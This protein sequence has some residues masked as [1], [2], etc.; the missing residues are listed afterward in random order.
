MK[1]VSYILLLGGTGAMGTNLVKVLEQQDGF[2]VVVTSRQKKQDTETTEYRQGNAHDTEWLLHILQEREWDA[3][4]DFMI[5]TT[6]EFHSRVELLLG[7]TKQYVYISS[8]RVYADSGDKLITEDSPRLLDVCNDKEYLK[9]D[10]YAL[11]KARQEDLLIHNNRKNW[12]IVRPYITFSHNR[13]QLGVMEKENWLIPALNNRPIVFS[14][15][16]A[17]HYTTMTDGYA[18]AQ[19]IAAVITRPN[20][21]GEIFHITSSQSQKWSDVLKWYMEAIFDIKGEY[22][23]VYY[24][25]EWNPTFGG[26][27]YQWKYDRLYDRS[28]DNSKICKFVSDYTSVSTELALKSAIKK[29]IENYSPNILDLNQ[30]VEI[31]RGVLTGDYLSLSQTRGKK[32]K[33][34]LIAYKLHVFKPLQNIYH[35]WKH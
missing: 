6:D 18:V 31:E 9:T 2:R 21:K 3:I 14:K 20:A 17:E 16:I 7:A 24:T 15:D 35:L 4:V 22:P 26:A 28:F 13:L 23:M 1:K 29:F 25:D 32:R 12:T 11:T 10:E 27:P 33:I 19:G 34:K 30:N 5:Y 8:A